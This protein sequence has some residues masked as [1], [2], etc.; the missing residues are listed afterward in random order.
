MLG[1]DIKEKSIKILKWVWQLPQNLLALCL[2]DLLCKAALRKYKVND[3]T[4]IISYVIVSAMSLG[5]YIFI[6]PKYLSTSI[7]HE[8]GHCRQSEILG[9]LYLPI[10]GIPSLSHNII[11][12]LCRKIGITWNYYSFYTEHWANKLVGLQ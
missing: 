12:V 6:N 5:N 8:Y 7:R 4:I 2:E 9:P 10:I 3:V 1:Q 11:R